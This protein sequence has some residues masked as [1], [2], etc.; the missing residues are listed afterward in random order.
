MKFHG[1]KQ[2]VT[3]LKTVPKGFHY[4]VWCEFSDDLKSCEIWTG[5]YLSQN[6]VEYY[7]GCEKRYCLNSRMG[8]VTANL[9]YG[10]KI[11]LTDCIKQ[12]VGYLLADL[13]ARA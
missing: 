8:E 2:T 13:E 9:D 4:Q 5:Q 1:I 7:K 3:D 11:S 10:E 12:A 6:E